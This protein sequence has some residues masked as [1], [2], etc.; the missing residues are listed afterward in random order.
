M[1]DSK[2]IEKSDSITQLYNTAQELISDNKQK[3]KRSQS[4]S[5]LANVLEQIIS[6]S[7]SG[8]SKELDHFYTT[9]SKS[10]EAWSQLDW[11]KPIPESEFSKQRNFFTYV[12][13]QLTSIMERVKT[14]ML[15]NQAL[16]IIS[17]H[18]SVDAII[19]VIDKKGNIRY[20]NDLLEQIAKIDKDELIGNHISKLLDNHSSVINNLK[21]GNSISKLCVKMYFKVCDFSIRSTVSVMTVMVYIRVREYQN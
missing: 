4:E 17:K 12:Y 8:E 2:Q 11:S 21:E 7:E 14:G 18:N 10:M 3:K 9:L 5:N 20:T 15:S 13:V 19:I 16:D 6:L 1:V